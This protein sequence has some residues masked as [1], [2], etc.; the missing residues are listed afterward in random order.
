MLDQRRAA[1][2]L[3]S[4][5]DS[6]VLDMAQSNEAVGREMINLWMREAAHSGFDSDLAVD[7]LAELVFVQ[8]L[9]QEIDSG[10]LKG[11]S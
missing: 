7:R 2:L 11:V 4:W 6:V 3:S 1:P 8:L 5:P 9:R 10:R